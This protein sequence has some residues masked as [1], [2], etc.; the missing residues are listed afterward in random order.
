MD[1]RRF[2]LVGGFL[3]AGKTTLIGLLAQWLESLQLRTGLVMN[4]QGRGLMDTASARGS[5][6]KGQVREIRGG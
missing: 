5:V 4:D 3:G 6:G 1:R 2:I